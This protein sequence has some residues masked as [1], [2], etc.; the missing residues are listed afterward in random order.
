LIVSLIDQRRP[1]IQTNFPA[2][3]AYPLLHIDALNDALSKSPQGDVSPVIYVI[4]PNGP[5]ACCHVASGDLRFVCPVSGEVDPLFVFAF[6]RTFLETLQEYLGDLSAASLK[7]NFDVVYQLLEEVL[8]DGYPLTTELNA[9]RDIVLPPS[10]FNKV[11]SVAGIPGLSKASGHPFSS[12]I[13]W[14]KAGLRYSNNEIRVD[15]VEDLDAVVNKSGAVL[16]NT[17]WGKI[18]ARSHLSGNPDLLMNFTNAQIITDCSFH[19]CVRLQRWTRDKSLSFIPPDGAFILMEY[20]VASASGML[21]NSQALPYSLRPVLTLSEGGGT[22]DLA[23]T[24]RLSKSIQS[25][26]VE[27]FLGAG[28]TSANCMASGGSSWNFD[29][30][31]L[32]L[33]WTITN[34]PPSSAHSLRGSFSSAVQNPRPARAFKTSFEINPHS[35]SSLKVDQLKVSVEQYKPYKGIRARAGGSIEFRW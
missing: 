14:R 13:P 1:I 15:I 31:S 4:G 8:D 24:S 30:K 35:F 17:V 32:V 2:S 23:L 18:H 26:N 27:I 9:L 29:P 5:S 20:R 3:S 28:A 6:L 33:R 34:A 10:F 21:A 16:T 7:D 25:I 19:P 22:L 12:P 11:V